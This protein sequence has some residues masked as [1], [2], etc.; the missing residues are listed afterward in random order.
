MEAGQP[1]IGRM[2][3]PPEAEESGRTTEYWHRWI[4][5]ILVVLL[6]C[7]SLAAA[8]SGYQAARWGSEH[9]TLFSEASSMRVE[10]TRFTTEAFIRE[11][12]DLNIFDG[13]ANAYATGDE[14]LA[15]FYERRFSPELATAVA[16]WQA[17]DPENNPDAPGGPLLMDAYKRP[18]LDQAAAL[19]EEA[20]RLFDE[21]KDA[22]EHSDGYVLTTVFLATVLFFAALAGRMSWLPP[23]ATLVGLAIVMLVYTMIRLVTFPVI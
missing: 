21:G 12:G 9:S 2:P 5:V 13:W 14:E 7:A 6:A 20:G 4:E 10:S 8:W 18:E 17:T 23:R 15:A 16:A 3:S 22:N 11:I 19:E 1:D